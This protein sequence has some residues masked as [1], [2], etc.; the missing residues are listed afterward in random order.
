MWLPRP[1]KVKVEYL[2]PV[3]PD[4]F[5][6]TAGQLSRQIRALIESHLEARR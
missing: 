1:G 5:A 2:T 3:T 4:R 6:S